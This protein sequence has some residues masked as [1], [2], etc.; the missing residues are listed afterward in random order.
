MDAHAQC[1]HA[2]T[3]RFHQALRRGERL[4][5]LRSGAR[6]VEECEAIIAEIRE[7]EGGAAPLTP[8]RSFNGA[9]EGCD[10]RAAGGRR[11]TGAPRELVA[12]YS[13]ILETVLEQVRELKPT[14]YE[15]QMLLPHDAQL[16][17]R[18]IV[19]PRPRKNAGGG[20]SDDMLVINN[21]I[22][23]VSTLLDVVTTC[24]DRA[25]PL[26][27][28]IEEN[29]ASSLPEH[30]ARAEKNV[31]RYH[32]RYTPIV[33]AHQRA[34]VVCPSCLSCVEEFR[35][36]VACSALSFILYFASQYYNDGNT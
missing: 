17:N 22:E 2:E 25:E 27:A 21:K 33:D 15:H 23:T 19:A 36:I 30:I 12:H 24:I 20:C 16:Q 18:Q 29:T 32:D 10:K 26:V 7:Q 8:R 14:P 6:I 35:I 3:P 11:G 28:R 4:L 13:A 5:A 1:I 9:L 31:R 34:G